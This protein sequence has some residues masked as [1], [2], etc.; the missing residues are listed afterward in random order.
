MIDIEKERAEFHKYALD[1]LGYLPRHFD[2]AYSD[3]IEVY[4]DM[5]IDHDWTVWQQRATLAAEREKELLAEIERLRQ[6][7]RDF[8]RAYYSDF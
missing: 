4:K 5:R 8:L 1:E 2:V 6:G 3:E 7:F